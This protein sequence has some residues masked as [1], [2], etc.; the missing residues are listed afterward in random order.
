MR[1][2]VLC[3]GVPEV[4][5]DE[6][7]RHAIERSIWPALDQN[8][9]PHLINQPLMTYEEWQHVQVLVGQKA[10]CVKKRSGERRC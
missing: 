5:Y 2:P 3:G 10:T 4:D 6:V 7:T 1:N 9:N 8:G